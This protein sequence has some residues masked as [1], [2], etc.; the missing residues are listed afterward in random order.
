MFWR[1]PQISKSNFPAFKFT[2]GLVPNPGG[3]APSMTSPVL[4]SP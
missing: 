3:L 2:F 4:C 1:P